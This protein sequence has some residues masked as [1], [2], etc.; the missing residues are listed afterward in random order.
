MASPMPLVPPVTMA[1]FPASAVGGPTS[2]V[3]EF[4]D[5]S[6]DRGPPSRLRPSSAGGRNRPLGGRPLPE[7]L[8]PVRTRLSIEKNMVSQ[9]I[10]TQ[11]CPRRERSGQ[12]SEVVPGRGVVGGVE[13]RVKAKS[14]DEL[15][16]RVG[17]CFTF[18]RRMILYET[19]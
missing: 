7:S 11:A 13:I 15:I 6:F 18:L 9:F 16:P 14:N 2:V 10:R 17:H 1:V 3:T 4:M 19:E 8:A 12:M 5:R